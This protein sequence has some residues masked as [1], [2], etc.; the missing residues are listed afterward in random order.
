MFCR[1]RFIVDV[2]AY[3]RDESRTVAKG[4]EHAVEQGGDGGLTIRTGYTHQLHALG[5][6]S[7]EA[8]G[9]LTGQHLAILY[10]HKGGSL[11]QLLRQVGRNL[12]AHYGHS[13]LTDSLGDVTVTICLC[14]THGHE[15]GTLCHGA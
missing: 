7:V 9:Q 15:E 14:T 10:H 2:V 1:H 12:F 11:F 4:A 13:S 8:G 6:I 3:G 5:W